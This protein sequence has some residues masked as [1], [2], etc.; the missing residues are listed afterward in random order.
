ML[1]ARAFVRAGELS[2]DARDRL[3]LVIAGEGGLRGQIETVLREARATDRAWL[4]G[5]RSDVPELMRGLD[6]FV[7]PSLAEGISNT[8]LE[9]MATAL[10]V[11]ATS[12]GG[13]VELLEEGMTGRLVP[14][15]DV[16]AMAQAM[17]AD[18]G[19]PEGARA[20]GIRARADVERRF[21]LQAMVGRYADL[22]ESL[23]ARHAGRAVAAQ[24]LRA[25][26]SD[27]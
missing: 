5:D 26:A 10:P 15:A 13:N 17:L 27:V 18:F 22:Y 21:T 1:L 14:P 4:A 6:A 19:D 24:R 11:V 25:P 23:L 2:V 12:V 7:L 16:E 20:R 8:I 3:R 9:A